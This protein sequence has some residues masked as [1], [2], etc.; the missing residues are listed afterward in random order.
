MHAHAQD[1]GVAINRREA[2]AL[3]GRFDINKDGALMCEECTN[4]Y[5]ACM[6]VCMCV[7]IF[8]CF[9]INKDGALMCEKRTNFYHACM[10][11]CMCACILGVSAS[12]KMV[13]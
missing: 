3:F 5:Y 13:C 1:L 12:T 11:V 10:H 6:H 4:L 2:Y 8:G 7:C 9:G